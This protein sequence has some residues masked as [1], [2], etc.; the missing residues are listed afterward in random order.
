MICP[1]CQK[2]HASDRYAGC[3]SRGCMRYFRRR[4]TIPKTAPV[5]KP[6]QPAPV[7]KP[8]IRVE[9]P[10]VVEKVYTCVN[11]QKVTPDWAAYECRSTAGTTEVRCVGCWMAWKERKRERDDRATLSP[12]FQGGGERV[13]RG[14][15]AFS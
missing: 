14:T 2:D 7:A 15:K 5:A 13:I 1:A 6:P 11:C 8:V 4:T 10:P 9:P 12:P 3:C